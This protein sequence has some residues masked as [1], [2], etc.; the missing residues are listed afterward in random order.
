MTLTSPHGLKLGKRSSNDVYELRVK[1]LTGTTAESGDLEERVNR[2]LAES[3][4][5][6]IQEIRSHT[7][8]TGRSLELVLDGK[9]IILPHICYTIEIWYIS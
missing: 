7:T 6:I 4:G 8:T 9:T 2:W 5:V 1:I 3:D